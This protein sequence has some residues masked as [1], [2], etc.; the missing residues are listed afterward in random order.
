MMHEQRET[1]S[2]P[3]VWATVAAGFE[4]T[5]RHLWLL[6]IPLL[7]DVFLWLG[8]RL[9]FAPLVEQ[10][11][12]QWPADIAAVDPRPALETIATRTN[13]FTNLSVAYLGVPTLWAGAAPEKTPLV[14]PVFSIDNWAAWAGFLLLLTLVGLL[15]SALYYTL[16]ARTVVRPQDALGRPAGNAAQVASW[17]GRTWLRYLALSLLF[18]AALFAIILPIAAIAAFVLLLSRFL[19]TLLLLS[20]PVLILWLLVFLSYTP[21]GLALNRQSFFRAFGES[22]RLLQWNLPSGITL[23]LVVFA[24]AQVMNWLMLA[25]DNGTWLTLA[26]LPAHAYISTALTAALFLFY[27]DRYAVLPAADRPSRPEVEPRL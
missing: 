21:A 25:A 22:V 1:S 16:I 14:A 27:R 7:L 20:A 23:L 15:L 4:L 5:T 12:A 13:L 24:G 2:L 18:L 26:S 10:L 6:V 8:P 9:S 19:G 11:I 17:I 3:G